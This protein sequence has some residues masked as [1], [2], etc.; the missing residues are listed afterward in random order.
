MIVYNI[1]GRVVLNIEPETM[2]H[3]AEIANVAA[4]KQAN[5][6]LDQAR[7]IVDLGLELYAGDDDLVLRS[8]SSAASGA[9][10]STPTSSGRR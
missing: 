9:S 2:A 5:P 3:L 10:A 7:A 4:V 6:D 1:P 8:S